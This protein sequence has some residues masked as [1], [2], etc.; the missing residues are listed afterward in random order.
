MFTEI[1][2]FTI[3]FLIISMGSQV[4]GGIHS[5]EYHYDQ[6]SS[7]ANYLSHAKQKASH[8]YNESTRV[9]KASY[10]KIREKAHDTYVY[11]CQKTCELSEKAKEHKKSI[12]AAATYLVFEIVGYFQ[13]WRTPLYR[14]FVLPG[15]FDVQ[16]AT[17]QNL[18]GQIN[19]LNIHTIPVLN[20]R[21]NTL[22]KQLHTVQ[23]NLNT[24]NETIPHL[25]G[26]IDR[27]KQKINDYRRAHK[28]H[29]QMY[30]ELVTANKN[31]NASTIDTH[32]TARATNLNHL[33]D[34]LNNARLKNQQLQETIATLNDQLEETQ[35]CLKECIERN[36]HDSNAI[37]DLQDDLDTTRR[38]N[39]TYRQE[40]EDLRSRYAQEIER[41][42]N[43]YRD[44]LE[45][46]RNQNSMTTNNDITSL[47][48]EH[49]LEMQALTLRYDSMITQKNNQM[50]MLEEQLRNLQEQ[51]HERDNRMSTGSVD[52]SI[53]S[54]VNS[55]NSSD[56]PVIVVNVSTS[57][58]TDATMKVAKNSPAPKRRPAASLEKKNKEEVKDTVTSTN[59][60]KN[61]D[62]SVPSASSN[63]TTDDLQNGRKSLKSPS[64]PVRSKSLPVES[65]HEDKNDMFTLIKKAVTQKRGAIEG[66]H[67]HNEE[68]ESWSTED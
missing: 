12:A 61:K 43:Q 50:S 42:E 6:T 30:D 29:T 65:K 17:N 8:I 34:Q 60:D 25:R 19:Q 49:T 68:D 16:H 45:R 46:V 53:H 35:A 41:M 10:N 56:T 15:D 27:R 55:T 62:S 9:A 23:G 1:K 40:I 66:S 59:T 31:N 14:L 3:A 64:I 63:P 18:N 58:S 47:V 22:N 36:A 48:N 37:Q 7:Q 26:K 38:Q 2:R 11:T 54:R 24:A 21:I 20:T 5:Q 44:S 13:G 28:A 33:T 39:D 32:R 52:E 57:V 4:Y 51:M 67:D